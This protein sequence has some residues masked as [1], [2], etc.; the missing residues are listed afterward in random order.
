MKLA[1]I[2]LAAGDSRR[3]GGNKLLYEL[4]GK[5]LYRYLTDE[6]SGLG[7]LLFARRILVT[8]YEIIAA[9]LEQQGYE[10]V[11]NRESSL[12][13]SHSIR[14]ALDRLGAAGTE[15]MDAACFAVCDQPYLKGATLKAFLEQWQQSGTG[16]GCLGCGERLGNPAVF[17]KR[18]FPELQ[19]L[20][21]DKGGKRV[22]RRHMEDVMIFPADELELHDIDVLKY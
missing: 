5:P 4:D 13:I 16:L 18:Y 11:R 6:L 22:L 8:Q 21:G 3:F 17:S 2:L 7:T 19:S 12:G 14:L 10:I 15:V 9:D 1:L 20:D